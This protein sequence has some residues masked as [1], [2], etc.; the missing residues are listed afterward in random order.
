M[1]IEQ[2][3]MLFGSEEDYQKAR[4]GWNAKPQSVDGK[5]LGGVVRGPN[6]NTRIPIGTR[7]GNLTVIGYE[8]KRINKN[9]SWG[10]NP[11]CLCGLCGEETVPLPNNLKK[12]RT[13]RCNKCAKTASTKTRKGYWGYADILPDDDHRTRLLNRIASIYQRCENPKAQTYHHYGGRGIQ[14]GFADRKEF[15]RYIITLDG[16][17]QPDLELDRVDNNGNYEIGNLRFATRSK[18]AAN[19]RQ[20]ADLQAKLSELEE[21][22]R[23]CTCGAAKSIHDNDR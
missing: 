5:L 23:R 8:R 18:N 6:E 14:V 15:L 11:V 19:K 9:K 10:W 4:R 17:D 21:R 13:T 2:G 20:V 1:G 16:W 22:L 12:G 3:R 7:F